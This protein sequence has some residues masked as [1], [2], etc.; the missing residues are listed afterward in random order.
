MNQKFQSHKFGTENWTIFCSIRFILDQTINFYSSFQSGLNYIN[1]SF[2]YK[3]I[4]FFF[5]NS[6]V[7]NIS[8]DMTQIVNGYILVDAKHMKKN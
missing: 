3:R 5:A 1:S 4:F 2:I 8:T 7:M 6:G